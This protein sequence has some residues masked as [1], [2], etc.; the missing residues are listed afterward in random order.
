MPPA[1]RSVAAHGMS[2]PPQWRGFRVVT[3][4][5]AGSPQ[6]ITTSS[7]AQT[8]ADITHSPAWQLTPQAPQLR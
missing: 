6:T 8:H 2:Q 5:I 1:Q 4:Q 3:A 7:S